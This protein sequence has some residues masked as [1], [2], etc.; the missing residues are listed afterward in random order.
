MSDTLFDFLSDVA[1]NNNRE[2]FSANKKRYETLREPW[3]NDIQQLINAMA[4]WEP[5]L[6]YVSARDCAYRFYRDT[7][8]STDKS[9]YKTF[10]SAL[11]SP[12]GRKCDKAAYYIHQGI[13]ECGIF[14][15]LWM[16]ES[17]ILK[18]VR[19]AIIDNIDEFHQIINNPDL[20]QRFPG[21]TGKKLKTAPKGYDRDHPEI[22][23][24]RLTEYGKVCH[25]DKDFF[26]DSNWPEKAAE[27]FAPLKPLIDFINYSIDE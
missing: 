2:W 5:S 20:L 14:G 1:Q 13:D 26:L 11:I 18:K 9:P 8:F 27:L 6:K 16:P 4:L 21:W 24:L 19:K 10:F 25:L 3:L 12:Y 7:R 15:G 23:L 17:H 22:E